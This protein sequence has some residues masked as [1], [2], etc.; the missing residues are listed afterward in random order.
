M[1][2][3]IV[4]RAETYDTMLAWYDDIN[5]LIGK[6]GAERNAFVT[7]HQRSLSRSS[8]RSVSSDGG[9]EE[10]EAD[11]VPFS[12]NQSMTNQPV[13]QQSELPS[14]PSPGGRFPS[15]IQVDRNLQ[16]PGPSS[17]SSSEVGL[18]LATVAGGPPQPYTHYPN[19]YEDRT[20]MDAA[21]GQGNPY[22]YHPDSAPLPVQ[23]QT[24]YYANN[25]PATPIQPT[26]Q[27]P[28]QQPNQPPVQQAHVPLQQSQDAVPLPQQR[29]PLP[30]F[31]QRPGSNYGEWMAPVAAGAAAGAVGVEAARHHQ[32]QEQQKEEQINAALA[33]HTIYDPAQTTLASAAPQHNTHVPVTPVAAAWP[34]HVNAEPNG[35]TTKQPFL[36][37]GE[38][39]VGAADD[40]AFNGGPVAL[41]KRQ[42]TDYSVSDLHVPGEYPK[43]LVSLA[44]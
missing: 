19:A 15:D 39:A 25:A 37:T 27:Q 44:K 22:E 5:S 14:R 40:T 7:K 20:P 1:W 6:T 10:D 4:C 34:T 31:G 13:A 28:S 23:H 17:G 35:H 36:G 8:A 21:Y 18:D 43:S 42:N 32:Q 16:A 9:L 24:S 2:S 33:N 11:R 30:S 26:Y 3:L 29:Q 41:V 12:A 38:A